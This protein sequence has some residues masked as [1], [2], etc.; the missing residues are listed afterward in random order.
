MHAHFDWLVCITGL[1][2]I[3]TLSDLFIHIKD[4]SNEHHIDG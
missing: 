3:A 1:A 2:K 4:K